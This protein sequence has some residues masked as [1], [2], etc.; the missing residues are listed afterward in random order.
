MCRVTQIQERHGGQEQAN[1]GR[2]DKTL[3]RLQV[4]EEYNTATQT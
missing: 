3:Q 2:V 1:R 4:G